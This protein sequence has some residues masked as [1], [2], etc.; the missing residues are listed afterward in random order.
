MAPP[1]INSTLAARRN[2]VLA[3]YPDL[4]PGVRQLKSSTLDQLDRYLQQAVDSIK[5]KKCEVFVAGTAGEAREYILGVLKGAPSVVVSGSRTLDE[6]SIATA[7]RAEGTEVVEASLEAFARQLLGPGGSRSL[8]PEG[9]DQLARRLGVKSRREVLD[10]LRIFLRQYLAASRY[11]LTGASAVVAATGSLMLLEDAGNLRGVANMSYTHIAVTGFDKIVPDLEGAWLL[12]RAASACRVG[13]DICTYL[14]LNTGP[15]QTGDIESKMVHGMHG[16]KEVHVVLLDNGRRRMANEGFG[17]AL[18]CMDC[19]ECLRVC[20]AFQRR[21]TGFGGGIYPG[22]IG[23]VMTAFASG[24]AAAADVGLMECDGCGR[25]RESCPLGIDI[26]GMI[27]RCQQD[28]RGLV[29]APPQ[30]EEKEWTR[31]AQ[32]SA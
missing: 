9:W 17:E 22:G 19:G 32:G 23:V 31:D 4:I 26:P 10:S 2:R 29:T 30:D 7:A 20:P 28:G 12:A 15:S 21:G 14:S 16:P 27:L 18:L 8:S 11:G 24:L 1:A 13:A 25:C 6:I 5:D 3:R